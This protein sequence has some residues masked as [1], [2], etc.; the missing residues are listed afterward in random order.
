MSGASH[1]LALFP[2]LAIAAIALLARRIVARDGRPSGQA[3]RWCAVFVI[4]LVVVAGFSVAG[5]YEGGVPSILGFSIVMVGC[6]LVSLSRERITGWTASLRCG[7]EIG[8]AVRD[9]LALVISA[10]SAFLALELPWND[11][12]ASMDPT[13]ASLEF[14]IILAFLLS[15]YF[16]LLRR[17]QLVSVAVAVLA[18]VGIAQHY[19]LV[20]KGTAIMPTDL[21][22][23]GT[24][25]AVSGGFVY[26]LTGGILRGL[27]FAGC[28]IALSSLMGPLPRVAAPDLAPTG[29][30]DAPGRPGLRRRGFLRGAADLA[31]GVGFGALG[32][33]IATGK[34]YYWTYGIGIDFFSPITTYKAEGFL[35]GFIAVSQDMAIK[36]P[37]GYDEAEAVALEDALARYNETDAITHAR[38][39]LASTQF[40]DLKPSIVCVMNE[41][42][43]DLGAIMGNLDCGYEGPTYLNSIDDAVARG[44]LYVS[45]TG[46][47]TCNT[48]FEFLTG[49]S[50]ANIG[51]SKYP[52]TLYDLT[53]CASLSAQLAEAGYTTTA[54]HSNLAKNWERDEVYGHF[55]FQTFLT[56]DDFAG[57][58]TFHNGVTDGATYD[59]ILEI[60]END[61]EP[62]FVFDVTMQNHGG[63]TVG[64]I[65]NGF[66]TDYDVPGVSRGTNAEVNEYLSCIKASDCDLGFFINRLRELDRPVVLVF[67]GDHQPPISAT[68]NDALYPSDADELAHKL[69]IYQTQYFVWANYDVAGCAQV[70]ERVPT[71]A[72]YLQSILMEQVGAPLTVSQQAHLGARRNMPALN[73]L[74]YMGADGTWYGRGT[75][76]NGVWPVYD[77]LSR[78]EYLEFGSKVQ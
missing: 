63:Y 23:I 19:V 57:A 48:E 28:G 71:S 29:E 70:S 69:R 35:P 40:S 50:M 65:S 67:F 52:Y 12:V 77:E 38:Y 8:R 41:S 17:G 46:G 51:S 45:V 37:D 74:G 43:S 42:F 36:E 25:A 26:T 10:L 33:W 30:T 49:Y 31:L 22:A 27:A 44:P 54:M 61:A 56:I 24:A 18:L 3:M 16:L 60:L 75:T 58:P 11:A 62:Q 21:Y 64:N 5:L 59:R 68:L 78:I 14:A 7:P 73:L 53:N 47:G 15:A 1:V 76:D 20:F 55:G 72:N 6:G 39:G 32:R 4:L 2:V 66:L 13:G 9:A 34:S